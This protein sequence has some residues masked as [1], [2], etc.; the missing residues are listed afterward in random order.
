MQQ[1][2]RLKLPS[3]VSRGGLR[4]HPDQ[5]IELRGS[6]GNA[7]RGGEAVGEIAVQDFGN[8]IQRNLFA[9]RQS[10][11]W[12]GGEFQCEVAFSAPTPVLAR[13]A[14]RCARS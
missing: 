6:A 10:R 3:A 11:S 14:F 12:R 5:G 7:A 4:V 1:R 2:R 9:K 8:G 13:S